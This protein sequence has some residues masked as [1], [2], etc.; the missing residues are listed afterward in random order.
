LDRQ[1]DVVVVDEAHQ[2][3]HIISNR[4]Q[5]RYKQVFDR[6]QRHFTLLVTGTPIRSHA[7][8]MASLLWL[9]GFRPTATGTQ[10]TDTGTDP[11]PPPAILRCLVTLFRQHSQRTAADMVLA[12][13]SCRHQVVRLAYHNAD[14]KQQ[15]Q[16]LLRRFQQTLAAHKSSASTMHAMTMARLFDVL[17]VPTLHQLPHPYPA[18]VNPKFMALAATLAR[19]P[20]DRVVVTSSYVAVLRELGDFLDVPCELYTGELSPLARRR[21]LQAFHR[22]PVPGESRQRVLLLSKAAGGTALNLVDVDR[23]VLFEP[24]PTYAEDDQVKSRVMRMGQTHSIVF[25]HYLLPGMDGWL[26]QAKK[27]KLAL[28]AAFL[29]DESLALTTV[30]QCRATERDALV[31]HQSGA[32]PEFGP[33]R[34]HR[35]Q[36]HHRSIRRF[37]GLAGRR[38]CF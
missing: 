14:Q 4:S 7:S 23:L 25:E 35:I 13:P 19:N 30:M 38:R 24:H 27:R 20:Q 32:V 17:M 8:D 3:G 34:M 6:L 5:P 2:F 1:F 28:T 12:M 18:S 29:P 9:A 10:W 31:Q 33:R 11:Q 16:R 21:V 15:G 26:W 36:R 22:P 37:K